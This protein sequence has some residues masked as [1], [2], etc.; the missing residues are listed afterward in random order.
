VKIGVFGDSFADKNCNK[1]WW[2]YLETEHAH[3]VTSYGQGGSGIVFSARLICDLFQNF[4]LVIWCL[5]S[6]NRVLVN[7]DEKQYHVT[8]ARFD[9][10]DP[11]LQIKIDAACQYLAHVFD[12]NDGD[13]V[14]RCIM[15]YVQKQVDNLLIVP[16]FPT[17]V[18]PDAA[19]AGFN[20]YDLC[21]I[22]TAHYFPGLQ[23]HEVYE[24][25]H[26]IRAGHLTDVNQRVLSELINQNLKPGLFSTAYTNFAVPVEP[27]EG[28]FAR[29]KK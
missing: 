7:H 1:I 2:K 28:A 24:R 27:L 26:D 5:T 20:L 21:G 15:S 4:D 19:A 29:I 8:G 16:S 10:D 13:F 9:C 3:D 23:V 12:W 14:G 18:Y 22:E 11:E 17:P 6:P 25:Y